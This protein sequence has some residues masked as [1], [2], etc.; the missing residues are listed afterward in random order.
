M[1]AHVADGDSF[2][3]IQQRPL[4]ASCGAGRLLEQLIVGS[5]HRVDRPGPVPPRRSP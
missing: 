3:H 5:S 4:D 1:L 2:E